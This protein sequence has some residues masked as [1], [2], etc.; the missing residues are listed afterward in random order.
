[1]KT[2]LKEP[3]I[4]LVYFKWQ[5]QPDNNSVSYNLCNK[6]GGSDLDSEYPIEY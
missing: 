4:H 5:T 2:Y 1:M 3:F 6:K